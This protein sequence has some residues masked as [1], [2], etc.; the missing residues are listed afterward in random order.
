M[1]AAVIERCKRLGEPRSWIQTATKTDLVSKLGEPEK[2]QPTN[3]TA[4][5]TVP[6]TPQPAIPPTVAM[7]AKLLEGELTPGLDEKTVRQIV[8]DELRT[9]FGRLLEV[10]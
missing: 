5:K 1:P 9:V 7:L 10:Y 3:G 6:D 8:R 2:P 4:H